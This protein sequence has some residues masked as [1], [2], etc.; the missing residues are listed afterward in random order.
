[1]TSPVVWVDDQL[2]SLGDPYELYWLAIMPGIVR[3]ISRHGEPVWV[4]QLYPCSYLSNVMW[5]GLVNVC[6][7]VNVDPNYICMWAGIF[8]THL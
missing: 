6:T 7:P 5:L 4:S 2:K 8:S 3:H 1:M